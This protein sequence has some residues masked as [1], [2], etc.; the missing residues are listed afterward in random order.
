MKKIIA[1]LA[2]SALASTSAMAAVFVNAVAQPGNAVQDFSDAGLIAFNL[3]LRNL[4][5]VTLNYT[6]TAEDLAGPITF[7]AVVANLGALDLDKV[8]FSLSGASFASIGTVSRSFGGTATVETWGG[9]SHARITL[10]APEYFE[11]EVGNPYLQASQIDWTIATGA[12]KAG[13]TLSI[14][15]AVPE[16]QTYA[17]VLA[18][19][20]VAGVIA[21]RRRG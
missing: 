6:L 11:L 1:S 19:L 21:R 5:N 20:A 14:T 13:D 8:S 9:N 12:L 15:V 7:N 4:S 3:D 18:G 10:D 16:P 2:L 17:M